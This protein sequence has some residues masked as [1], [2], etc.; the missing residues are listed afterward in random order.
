[1]KGRRTVEKRIEVVI[2]HL[3]EL[4]EV[5]ASL[6]ARFDFEVDDEVAHRGFE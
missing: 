6:G 3:A 2:V 5:L 4:K 1:M